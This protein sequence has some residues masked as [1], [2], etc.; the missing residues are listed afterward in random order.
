MTDDGRPSLAD[1]RDVDTVYQPAEDSKL[2]ADA[3][4]GHLEADRRVLDL[5]TGSGYVGRRIADETGADVVASDVSPHA[6]RQARRNG[7][8]V[9]RGHLLDPFRDDS[10]DAVAFNAPYLPTPPDREWDDWMETALSGGESGRA[11]VEPFL[12]DLRRV[13]ASGGEAFLLISSLTGI[14]AVR[15]EARANGLTTMIVAEEAHPNERL[16]VLHLVPS[17]GDNRDA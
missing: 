3:A 15:D 11:V 8:A 17:R 1:R 4:V 6:C 2:L 7:L 10:L 9:V 13:L 5:G 14:D 12:D 16:V